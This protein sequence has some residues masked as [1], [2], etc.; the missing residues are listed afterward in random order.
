MSTEKKSLQVRAERILLGKLLM[1]SQDKDISLRKLFEYPLGP[2]PWSLAT[3]DGGMVKTNEAQL[4]HH[5][6]TKST[7]SHARLLTDAYMSS[8]AMLNCSPVLTCRFSNVS[9]RH[10]KFIL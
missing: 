3:A 8:K 1:L 5:L 7:P 10:R 9:P 2:I 6:E 4:L